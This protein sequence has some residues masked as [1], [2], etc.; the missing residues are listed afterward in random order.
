MN[1]VKVKKAD[2][3]AQKQQ[4]Q[5]TSLV[6]QMELAI[7]DLQAAGQS[8]QDIFSIVNLVLQ[9]WLVDGQLTQEYIDLANQAIAYR[10][11]NSMGAEQEIKIVDT[12]GQAIR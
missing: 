9:G 11:Q 12:S 7:L 10:N 5:A 4:K 3:I 2:K 8:E 6:H 1:K